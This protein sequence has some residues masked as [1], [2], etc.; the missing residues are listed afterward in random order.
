MPLRP[1]DYDLDAL[2]AAARDGRCWDLAGTTADGRRWIIGDKADADRVEPPWGSSHRRVPAGSLVVLER[3]AHELRVLEPGNDLVVR[4]ERWR[5]GCDRWVYGKRL[6]V[7]HPRIGW[8]MV[9]GTDL[10]D[11]A[12]SFLAKLPAD[13]GAARRFA[14]SEPLQR[15]APFQFATTSWGA[16]LIMCT[17]GDPQA[18]VTEGVAPLHV[19]STWAWWSD[20]AL[21]PAPALHP[22]VVG[23]EEA[24]AELIG[25]L[26]GVSASYWSTATSATSG[27]G[28]ATTVDTSTTMCEPGSPTR[29]AS[30]RRAC[31]CRRLGGPR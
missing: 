20:N 28:G 12:V 7:E 5:T 17:G 22:P 2:N 3:S 21:T 30:T 18:A 19:T 6:H 8:T 10:L 9:D 31:C 27:C 14:I 13:D 11:R 26:W 23:L 16:A 15:K 24:A 29:G 1:E 25:S 4:G